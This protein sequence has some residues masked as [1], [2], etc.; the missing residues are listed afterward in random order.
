M[1]RI[2]DFSKLGR[3]PVK[4]LRYYDEIGL[5]KPSEVNRYNRYR[6]YT[7]EQLPALNRILVLKELGF[8]LEQIRNLLQENLSPDQLKGMLQLRHSEIEQQIES[9]REQL[10]Q[11]EARLRQ[12]EQGDRLPHY[13][14]LL[15]SVEPQWVAAV[16][17][18]ISSY[19]QAGA[20]FDQL[21]DAILSF[22]DQQGVKTCGP[23]IAIY[24]DAEESIPVEAAVPILRPMPG[25]SRVK[26]YQ[27]PGV[28]RMATVLHHGSF[29]TLNEAYQALIGWIKLNRYRND[30]SVREVYLKYERGGDPNQTVTEIQFPVRKESKAMQPEIVH[31]DSFK[32][33]GLHYV[34]K[35]EHGEISQMWREFNPRVLEIRHL[36]PVKEVA[37]GV[38]SPCEDPQ[39]ID[40]VAGLPVTSLEDIPQGMVGVEVPAQSYVVFEAHGVSDIG[41]TYHQILQ[42]WLPSS[43]YQAGDGP[44]FELYPDT[45]DSGNPDESVLYIYFPIK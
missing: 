16:G 45:F 14:V 33:V 37:Y 23:G 29:I 20:T 11:V 28:K 34:G 40:Y 32:V 10:A 15:K 38:C 24:G 13:D 5:L 9:S 25:S 42:E 6:Y 44:D 8:P 21:F 26:V 30:G 17:G 2:G 3:V 31:K 12:I 27:L 18:F 1:F 39:V 4:T 7:V 22:L 43:K 41:A 19:E 35:N 36:A